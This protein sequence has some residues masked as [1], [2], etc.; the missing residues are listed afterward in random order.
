MASSFNIF[1]RFSLGT[2][3]N[4]LVSLISVPVITWFVD[5]SEMGR[6][7]MFTL[8]YNL[9]LNVVLLGLDQSFVR[10]FNETPSGEKTKILS[11]VGFP[12]IVSCMVTVLILEVFR[13]PLAQAFF[14]TQDGYV[15]DLLSF[16]I[17][18][19]CVNRYASLILRMQNR[20]IAYSV[21][22][23][24][25]T[26][27]NVLI[28][29]IFVSTITKSFYA[30][31]MAFAA[32]QFVALFFGVIM[33]RKLWIAAISSRIKLDKVY[34]KELLL[35][36]LPFVPTLAFDWIFQSSDRTFL[37]IFSTFAEIGIYATA[38]R[39]AGALSIL[40]VGF[41]TFW[42]PFVFDRFTKN[43]SDKSFYRET[44]D[45]V[46]CAFLVVIQGVL[47]LKNLLVFVLPETYHSSIEIFPLLLFV[48]MF[49]A[50]SDITSVG[51]NLRKKTIYHF[52]T[53]VVCA[54]ISIGCGYLLIPAF[55]AKGAVI[56]S[57]C[58]YLTFFTLRTAFGYSLYQ[59]PLDWKAFVLTLTV[60]IA[61]AAF[62]F[63]SPK[64]QSYLIGLPCL[65]FTLLIYKRTIKRLL[66]RIKPI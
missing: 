1:L 58:S 33:E 47:M 60:T 4:A 38:S 37:R 27:T 16:T 24:A 18:M 61:F 49:Y 19:G 62:T 50:L 23:F 15:V 52:V 2:W 45:S 8:A 64:P 7:T 63:L 46:A 54:F 65:I 29:I 12:T 13:I 6:A 28:T 32:A 25:L 41:T 43:D 31:V 39:I 9:I 55:G 26:L 30:I 22:Q 3:I 11:H 57:F 21:V 42:A 20:A 66:L 14:S 35:Y 10:F 51:I 44:F 34:T 56:S 36:G 59:L 17:V 40:Q 5:P 53:L 48:P